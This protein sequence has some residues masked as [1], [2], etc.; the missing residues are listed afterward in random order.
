MA[1]D[2]S[3]TWVALRAIK[4]GLSANSALSAFRDA[5]GSIRR[6]TFLK[7]YSQL[8]EAVKARANEVTRPLE[9]IPDQTEIKT[10]SS[11][12]A[13]G[14]M[15]VVDVRYRIKGTDTV[16]SRS[17][18]VRGS[19]LITRGEAVQQALTSFQDNADS[20]QYEDMV[21]LGGFYVGSVQFDPGGVA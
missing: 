11:A 2:I 15:Q 7:L 10:I 13:S 20:S 14:Y 9:S 12:K 16:A 3:P 17:Y 8:G 5:G 19:D 6:G 1:G 4:D 21:V 18:S